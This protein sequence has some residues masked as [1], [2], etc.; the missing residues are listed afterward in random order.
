MNKILLFLSTLIFMGQATYAS[1]TGK[2][3][4]TSYTSKEINGHIQNW[5]IIQDNRGV[6]Y[7]GDGYGVQ[8]FDGSTWRLILAPN[9]SFGRCFAKDI[10]GRIYVGSSNELGYLAADEHG[11]MKYVSLMKFIKPED[12]VFNYV[13]SVQATADGI[14][15]QTQERLFRFRPSAGNNATENWDVKVWKPQ[16]NFAYTFWIDQTLYVQQFGVGLMKMVQDSLIMVPGGEQFANDRMQV[17]LPFPGKPGC[18]LLGTFSRGLFIWDGN[19]FKPF[20]TDSDALLRNGPLY[21]GVSLPDSCFALGSI[22]NGLYIID[23]RGKTK[24]HLT[25]DSRLLSNTVSVLFVDA[26]NN[27]WVGMDGGVAILEYNSPLTQFDLSSGSSPT[28]ILRSKG[29]LYTA[30][31]TGVSFLDSIDS[32]F[33][34]VAGITGNSQAFYFC[35]INNDLFINTGSGIYRILGKQAALALP[36]NSLTFTFFCLARSRQDSS[37]LFGGMVNGVGLLHYDAKNPRRLSFI[38]RV[39]GLHGYIRYLIE[40]EPGVI[41]LSTNDAGVIRLKFSENNFSNPSIK[42]Y[43][44]EQGLPSGGI[45]AYKVIDKLFFCT[46]RGV[47]KFNPDQ[48][49]FSLDPF[50]DRVNLGRNPDEGVICA[51][52]DG[53]IWANLGSETVLF[54]RQSNGSYQLQKELLSRFAEDPAISIYPEKNGNVWFGVTNRAIRLMPN[55]SVATQISFRALIRRV[56]FAGDSVYYYGTETAQN[57]LSDPSRRLI[58]FRL[59]ALRFEFAAPS[60]LNP[61]ENKFRTRLEG[62]D[63]NWSDW[64]RETKQNYTNL[65]P[66]KYRFLVQAKNIYNQESQQAIFAFTILNPWYKTVWAYLCYVLFAAGFVLGL[67][68]LRT[69]QLQERSRALEKTVQER[70]AEIQTQKNNVEQLSVIGRDITDNL[71]IKDIINTVYENVNTLMDASVFG[72][73]LYQ[74]EKEQ[75]VFPATKEKGETLPE[76][77]VP[78]SDQNRL[79]VWC[80]KNQRDVIINDYGRD[81]IKYIQE[82]KPAVA[83][84]NPES[85]LYLLLQH[86]DKTIGVITA[87][88]FNKNA[89]TEYHLN[90]LRNLA[91]Y[92][93]IA[94]ENADAYH[95]V[96]ELLTDL[97]TTQEKLV[98]QSKLAALGALTAGIAH[99]IK[100]PLNFVNNFAELT[101]NLVSDLRQEINKNRDKLDLA[102]AMNIDEMLDTIQQNTGKINEHGKRADSIVRSMLQHSRGKAGDRQLTDINA[103][104]EEDINLAYHGMRALDSSFNIKIAKDLDQSIGKLEVVPQDVSRVF[105]NIISNGCYEAHRKK[106]STDGSFAPQLTVISRNRSDDVEIRIRDNGNGIPKE[107]RDKMFTPFFTTKPAGL[108]TGLGLSISYEIIVHE[109]HGELYFESEEGEFTEFVITLPK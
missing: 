95:Q 60:F 67:I 26:Q 92:S 15:F 46:K 5:A 85:I 104:L 99:E 65:P 32:Q 33:K 87:Q 108:G 20:A 31:N 9:Q 103:M 44:T 22:S 7:I 90:M 11:L 23:S 102:D 61:C 59:N 91:T 13:W 97:K 19:S 25:Q 39:P 49:T 34:S 35:A 101:G 57:S 71:S 75:L 45:T 16:N 51:D 18:Y 78:L 6:M 56:F 21:V 68:S 107:V 48:E 12:Q 100:N 42:R 47:Y 17:M 70:T 88:S 77:S 74:A 79:A 109:H 54:K 36:T 14:Y 64:S 86:K 58:P 30:E 94:L 98:T 8:E 89:Y 82:L 3:F 37:I 62:F 40:S 83:G 43:G 52:E 38:R 93:A 2:P 50:F 76:F 27:I 81:Y 4:I 24:L 41:W 55:R 1:E 105:L 96:N 29:I 84:E 63:K 10:I 106:M 53:N 69:H 66:G 72:I 80:F 73:G 28:D